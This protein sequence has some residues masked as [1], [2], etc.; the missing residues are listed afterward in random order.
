VLATTKKWIAALVVGFLVYLWA[1]GGLTQY[2]VPPPN[3][4]F[5]HGGSSNVYTTT[6]GG[7]TF[8]VSMSSSVYTTTVGTSTVITTSFAP[9]TMTTV[10]QY[11]TQTQTQTQTM[12]VQSTPSGPA[13]IT[14]AVNKHQLNAGEILGGA[15]Y[16]NRVGAQIDIYMRRQAATHQWKKILSGL[17]DSQGQYTAASQINVPGVYEVKATLTAEG[18]DSNILTIVVVGFA[19]SVDPD[20]VTVTSVAT[21]Q[22]YCNIGNMAVEIRRSTDNFA[23][24]TTIHSGNLD[25]SGY[26]FLN[27]NVGLTTGTFQFRAYSPGTGQWTSNTEWLTVT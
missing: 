24:W 14:I 7:Q 3:L 27:I 8:I 18:K 1:T 13:S 5:L 16:T 6:V 23:T 22:V 2:G 15:V 11:A 10:T 9:F 21:I 19:I 12:T 20:Q 4:N 17:T 25:A 26:L